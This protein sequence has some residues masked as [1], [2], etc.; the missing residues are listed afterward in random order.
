MPCLALAP[1]TDSPPEAA[2]ADEIS[3]EL[4][5]TNSASCPVCGSSNTYNETDANMVTWIVCMSCGSRSS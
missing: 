5:P 4:K 3:P 2:P 1:R